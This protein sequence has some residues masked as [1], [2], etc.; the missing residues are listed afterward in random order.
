MNANSANEVFPETVESQITGNRNTRIQRRLGKISDDA[1]MVSHIANFTR[2]R[3]NRYGDTS[4][5]TLI[6]DT[7]DNAAGHAGGLEIDFEAH[8]GLR[9]A[10]RRGLSEFFQLEL[11][12]IRDQG[13]HD[14]QW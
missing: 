14:L 13:I 8:F 4:L 5:H 10:D 6:E 3:I 1:P 11:L 12:K 2:G 9:I 7:N